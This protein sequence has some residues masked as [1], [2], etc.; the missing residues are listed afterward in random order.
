M[1]R[2]IGAVLALVALGWV[3]VLI[4]APLLPTPLAGLLYAAGALICHQIP[5]RTFHLQSFQLPVCA[6][7]FGLYAGGAMGSAAAALVAVS[8][9]RSGGGV[10]ASSAAMLG[11]NRRLVLTLVAAIPTIVTGVLEHG[12][13][14]PVSNIGRAVAAVPLAG[15]VAFVVVRAVTEPV[16]AA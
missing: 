10:T 11:T 15:V 8:P 12:F 6:R 3:A 14:V 7:C 2:W 1:H 16:A 13:G 5:E 9:L 4:A